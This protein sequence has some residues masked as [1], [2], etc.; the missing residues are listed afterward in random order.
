MDHTETNN[1]CKIRRQGDI[2][3]SAPRLIRHT[4]VAIQPT[5]NLKLNPTPI[6]N[7]PYSNAS[8]MQ[9]V[10]LVKGFNKGK[11]VV[12]RQKLSWVEERQGE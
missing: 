4:P 11:R 3:I 12:G 7:F 10:K 2:L 6:T 9:T 1:A 8:L 5:R